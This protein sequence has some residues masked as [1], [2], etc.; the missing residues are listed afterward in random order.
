[1]RPASIRTTEEIITSVVRSEMT[2][3]KCERSVPHDDDDDD[4]D[5]D[6]KDDDAT[7]TTTTMTT[8]MRKRRKV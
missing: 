3:S 6:D 1:M 4:D 2:A 5:D 7:T 8:T